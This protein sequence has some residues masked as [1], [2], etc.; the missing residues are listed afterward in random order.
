MKTT[1]TAALFSLAVLGSAQAAGIPAGTPG[2]PGTPIPYMTTPNASCAAVQ[3]LV[4]RRN[5]AYLTFGHGNWLVGY[6]SERVVKDHRFCLY[7]EAASPIW[8]PARD[9]AACFA[10]FTC[11]ESGTGSGRRGRR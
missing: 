4:A 11:R 5:H 8:V 2:F 7:G 6:G 9:T 1:A 3:T 10:G